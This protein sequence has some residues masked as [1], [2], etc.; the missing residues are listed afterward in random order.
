MILAVAALFTGACVA[1][2]VRRLHFV[3]ELTRLDPAAL[4][5][6][7]HEAG[8]RLPDEPVRALDATLRQSTGVEW[9]RSVVE[10]VQHEPQARPAFLGEVM[11]ELDYRARRWSRVPR[12]AASLA[13]TGGFLLASLALR[14]GL[15][16]LA[17]PLLE[18]DVPSVNSAVLDALD[19]VA[20]GMAGA[21]CCV[22]VQHGA[23]ATL[24]A[25][26]LAAEQL[27]DLLEGL[28]SRNEGALA[29]RG[30]RASLAPP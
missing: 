25:K 9:E 8:E 3:A 14:L 11:T 19:V 20:M 15:A 7:L 24:R 4:V 6:G 22:A 29:T 13:S 21:A 30:R 17:G 27:V 26:L 2:S 10:A 12:V 5:S 1:A 23:R 18:S 28:A 16:E